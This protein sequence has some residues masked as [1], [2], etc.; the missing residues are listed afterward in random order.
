MQQMKAPPNGTFVSIHELPTKHE[1]LQGQTTYA[2]TD[3]PAVASNGAVYDMVCNY[4]I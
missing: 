2:V 4:A 3:K 1:N